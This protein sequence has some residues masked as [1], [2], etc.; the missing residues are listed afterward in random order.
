MNIR[1][2]AIR[3]TERVL[4]ATAARVVPTSRLRGRI[5]ILSYHNILPADESASGDRSLH[6]PADRF[7]EQLDALCDSFAV[8]SLREALDGAREP[9]S[10]PCVVITID[11]AYLGAVRYGIPE[12]ARRN[13][14]ATVFVAPAYLAGRDFWWDAMANGNGGAIDGERREEALVALGGRDD[15][16]RQWA[17]RHGYKQV[18]RPDVFRCATEAELRDALGYDGLTLGAHSWTHPNLAELTAAELNVELH[19]CVDWLAQFGRRGVPY[20]AYPYGRSS[21]L[22]RVS[23]ADVGFLG[24]LELGGSWFKKSEVD[25]FRIPRLN[26]PSGLTREGFILRIA[27]IMTG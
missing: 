18:A 2:S 15:A 11:D 3:F 6:L 26:I 17:M 22:A 21:P 12:L 13:L 14:P 25:R 4:A 16:V 8:L 9:D 27:G 10:A 19:R 1:R 7:A 5:L 23:A 20:L 24:G